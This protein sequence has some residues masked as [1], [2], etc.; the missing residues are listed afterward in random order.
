MLRKIL[1]VCSPVLSLALAACPQSNDRS[2]LKP[3]PTPET[4]VPMPTPTTPNAATHA[5]QNTPSGP[6]AGWTGPVFQLS[7]DY[8]TQA[9]AA[10]D[11][12][13]CTWLQLKVDFGDGARAPDWTRGGW[14]AYMA[15]LLTYIKQGQDPD[16]AN[17]RGFVA[18]V[19]G[20]TRWYH[21]PWM[22]YDPTVGRDFVHGTTN[23]RTASLG[24]FVGDKGGGVNALPPAMVEDSCEKTW[25]HG[26]ETWAVGMYNEYGGWVFGN[27]FPAAGAGAGAPRTMLDPTTQRL[28]L[29]GLPFPQGTLVA[30]IL[31]TNAP[32]DCVAS[33]RN[34]PEWQ[35]H[36]HKTTT[37]NEYLCEREVATS[38]VIQLDVAVVDERSPTR[39]VYG[40]FVYDGAQPGPTFWDRLV[41][42]G[43][44]WGSDDKAWPAVKGER[45]KSAPV[46]QSVLNA[47]P[48]ALYEHEGCN[49]RLAGPVDSKMSSCISCHG[50][51][52]SPSPAGTIATLGDNEPPVFGFEG[53]CA[54]DLASPDS[55]WALNNAYFKDAPY[56]AAYTDPAY[57]SAIPLDTSLQLQVAL[58]Q[59]AVYK[60]YNAPAACTLDAQLE[61]AAAA[62]KQ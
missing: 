16:L 19:D 50:G 60:T 57:A 18:Q 28:F 8:P 15:A 7:H 5:F 54:V 26:F 30:K 21:V 27:A 44:Q 24:D 40:T 36:R 14:A 6:P 3:G 38:R 55:Q 52:F 48:A 34:S 33:L 1:P 41:P 31:T 37:S 22:A 47:L 59:Y 56:P 11:P 29:A 17:D 58:S 9:P 23:E 20:K 45:A 42:L 51:S 13:V 62:P 43:V 10:C 49:G 61:Q 2:G 46:V 12:A 53:L 32:V 35:I 4:P 25:A 39:W